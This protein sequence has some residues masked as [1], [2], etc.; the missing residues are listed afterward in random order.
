MAGDA[1]D[2]DAGEAAVAAGIGASE[3]AVAPATGAGS[4]APAATDV[5][6]S[7]EV[8]CWATTD[9]ETEDTPRARLAAIRVLRGIRARFWT[10]TRRNGL[11]TFR[12]GRK[13]C[14]SAAETKNP[15]LG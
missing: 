12:Q 15:G 10:G 7:P 6:C 8:V 4:A 11:P 2:G 14:P 13:R 1:G 9:G 5:P 3:G